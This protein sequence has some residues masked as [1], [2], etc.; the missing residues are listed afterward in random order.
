MKFKIDE[1][2]PTEAANLFRE[3]GHDTMTVSDQHLV[4][5][6]DTDIASVCQ[7]EGRILV[8]LDLDFS[9]IRV[10][11]PDEFPGLV[12][13]RLRRQDKLRVLAF[14]RRIIPVLSQEPINRHLW[15]VEENKIRI[16]G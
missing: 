6:P 9:D 7:R 14:I 3:A 5:S 4:G 2:L 11:Q 16:R 12:V 13:L 8:T 1:N 10:Y 15:I